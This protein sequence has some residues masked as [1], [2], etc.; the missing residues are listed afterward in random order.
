MP[1]PPSS[2]VAKRTTLSLVLMEV[3]MA[4]TTGRCPDALLWV[5]L[6]CPI[7]SGL[8]PRTI[9]PACRSRFRDHHAEE[10]SAE[11]QQPAAQDLDGAA[12]TRRNR[13]R[14]DGRGNRQS[15]DQIG[16]A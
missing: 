11:T 9:Q 14:H 13:S 16:R 10:E 1:Q 8:R 12:G 5:C 7:L 3:D 6:Y 2:T 4:R 15:D